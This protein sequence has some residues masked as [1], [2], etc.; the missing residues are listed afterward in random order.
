MPSHIS[1]YE[2]LQIPRMSTPTK[3]P[4][5]VEQ[6]EVLQGSSSRRIQG[7]R[8]HVRDLAPL[9][10][11]P[12]S[13]THLRKE[14]AVQGHRLPPSSRVLALVQPSTIPPNELNAIPP[15]SS[16]SSASSPGVNRLGLASHEIEIMGQRRSKP[17]EQKE[18][19]FEE[20]VFKEM[21]ERLAA[22]GLG[23]GVKSKNNDA[24]SRGRSKS[25][26]RSRSLSRAIEYR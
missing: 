12:I 15:S 25:R 9:P 8:D 2:R 16:A 21:R 26:S 1:A 5:S 17:I 18:Y 19:A 22:A 20:E 10:P 14:L 23:D 11:A 4:C 24:G 6:Q 7:P 13:A 3:R